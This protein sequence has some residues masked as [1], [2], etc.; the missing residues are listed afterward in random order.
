[1]LL[2]IEKAK[3]PKYIFLSSLII[4]LVTIYQRE[5]NS[6]SADFSAMSDQEI[7]ETLGAP[8]TEPTELGFFAYS[9]VSGVKVA[10]VYVLPTVLYIYRETS[11]EVVT[12]RWYLPLYSKGLV[13]L[14]RAM[15]YERGSPI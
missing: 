8:E 3:M 6:W 2:T 12:R 4:L 9:W 15:L 10:D 7:L 13:R 1:M 11:G 5:P 14:V